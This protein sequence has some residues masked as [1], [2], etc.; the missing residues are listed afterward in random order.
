QD[1]ITDSLTLDEH[2]D[3]LRTL[4]EERE[5]QAVLEE[6]PS[7]LQQARESG[8]QQ[9]ELQ[10]QR[11]RGETLLDIGRFEETVTALSEAWNHLSEEP[12]GY[13]IGN[14]LATAYQKQGEYDE[15]LNL[16]ME[17]MEPIRQS[18]DRRTEAGV[19]QNLGVAY[20]ALGD[21]EE[22][23]KRYTSSLEILER[24]GDDQTVV[25]ILNN[26]GELY[27]NEE[28]METALDYLSRSHQ[29][30]SEIGF[31]P[32]Q[33]MALMNMGL[34][35]QRMGEYEQALDRFDR[36]LAL[37]EDSGSVS[38]PIQLL[39]NR[40]MV[41]LELGEYEK[42]RE[43]F[44]QS[45]SMSSEI[46]VA[47]GLY[48]NRIGMGDLSSQMGEYE[49]AMDHY[50]SALELGKQS[51]SLRMKLTP[52]RGLWETAAEYGQEQTAL[53]YLIQYTE[54]SDSL[55]NQDRDDALARY[56]VLLDIQDERRQNQ[57][58]EEQVTL[59]RQVI[60]SIA[61]SG[62]LLLLLIGFLFVMYRRQQ[63]LSTLLQSRKEETARLNQKLKAQK[64][65]LDL[66]NTTKDRLISVLAHDLR[67]PVAQL[68]GIATLIR[69]EGLDPDDQ[70]AFLED[71]DERLNRSVAM[72][73]DYLD[74][75]QRQM[76]GLD[77][78]PDEVKLQEA[79]HEVVYR[80]QSKASEK[81]IRLQNNVDSSIRA[82]ADRQMLL[83]ILQNL[84]SN[85]IK[86]S[87]PDGTVSI[88]LEPVPESTQGTEG[89]KQAVPAASRENGSTRPGRV[90]LIVR[91]RGIGIP[92]HVQKKIFLDPGTR[93][94]GTDN[95][96]GTGLGL[97]ICKEFAEKQGF[98]LNFRST[99]GK[100]SDFYLEMD[101]IA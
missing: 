63:R 87:Y 76:E 61:G 67:A 40:G 86:F 53:D 34:V 89:S 41:Y 17:I 84:I 94:S 80:M 18:G 70:E 10:L 20:A 16:Y 15:A 11:I 91:D 52:L 69:E 81:Q 74:W 95:E 92:E 55:R 13:I 56:Q 6:I 68:Q 88:L 25:L 59:Q 58:L 82:M 100:G 60:W 36:S 5:L 24:L 45:L 26:I 31:V 49:E 101:T 51:G 30:A 77:P 96:A 21:V 44:R 47:Q 38:R 72:L 71:V 4:Y 39:Y 23:L 99:S 78:D 3:R 1:S 93:R 75:A 7:L 29:L 22:A 28:E 32:G 64:K 85:A 57:L 43:A 65:R 14:L 2:V 46:G 8:E 37:A 54:L 79:V 35:Y 50:G 48:Y 83:V 33:S 9:Q 73:Q 19:Q 90:R 27:R 12:N 98:T 66:L 42:A 97:I 62:I